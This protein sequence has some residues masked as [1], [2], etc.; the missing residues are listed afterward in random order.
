L[1]SVPL[2]LGLALRIVDRP[3]TILWSKGCATAF[4]LL[5]GMPMMWMFR[6]DGV[7]FSLIGGAA[8]EASILLFFYFRVK[9]V[10]GLPAN[11]DL[12]TRTLKT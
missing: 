9:A 11:S 10:A 1:G 12:S 3:N 6:M 4:T 8:I 7:I 2:I 5:L